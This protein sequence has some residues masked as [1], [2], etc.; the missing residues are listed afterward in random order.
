VLLHCVS[1][2]NFAYIFISGVIIPPPDIRS[3]VDKTAQFVARNG[4][5]FESRI[6]NSSEGKTAK[7]NFMKQY[8]PYHAY[9]ELK[10]RCIDENCADP[11]GF[12][13]TFL[14]YLIS[15]L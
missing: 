10:I 8:D 13:L 6:L 4:K 5:S 3:V 7:F 11:F 12:A 2:H 9:Y 1:I 15:E 14:L